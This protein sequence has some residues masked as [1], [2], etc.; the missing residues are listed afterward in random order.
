LEELV[1]E[2][3]ALEGFFVE[4]NLPGPP[5]RGGGRRE[6]DIVGV[7]IDGDELHIRHCEVTTFIT[8]PADARRY[9][10][11]FSET[12]TEHVRNEFKTRLGVGPTATYEK[13]V[14]YGGKKSETT[15]KRLH[16][17]IKSAT[18]MS[19]EEFIREQVIPGISKWKGSHESAKGNKP[20]LPKD[21]WL[22][23]LLEFLEWAR[24]VNDSGGSRH[25]PAAARA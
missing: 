9:G 12:V 24:S 22:L 25:A 4:T 11:K 13:W 14:I 10:E 19:V 8:S 7:K 16:D 5:G 21:R 23:Q 15:E 20:T 6:P 17:Q 1:A 18:V 2:W 3:L